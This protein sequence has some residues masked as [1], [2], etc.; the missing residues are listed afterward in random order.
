MQLSADPVMVPP[1]LLVSALPPLLL[2]PPPPVTPES[3]TPEAVIDSPDDVCL[4][5][6]ASLA[7]LASELP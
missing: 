4:F 3:V 7:T 5:S 1:P 6:V 2:A